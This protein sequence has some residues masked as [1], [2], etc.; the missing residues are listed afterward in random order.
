MLKATIWK[1]ELEKKIVNSF[2]HEE[3][4]HVFK[5][6]IMTKYKVHKRT[7]QLQ[8]EGVKSVSFCSELKKDL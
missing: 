2:R 7:K 4:Y 6:F 3:K 5:L 8:E 1:L